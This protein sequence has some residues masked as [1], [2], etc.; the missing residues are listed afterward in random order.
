LVTMSPREYECP[1]AVTI[2]DQASAVGASQMGSEAGRG[3]E[4]SSEEA[5]WRAVE[6]SRQPTVSRRKTM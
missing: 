1:V 6:D 5:M 4:E 2:V 3:N